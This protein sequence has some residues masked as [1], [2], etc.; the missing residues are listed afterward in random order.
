MDEPHISEGRATLTPE[1]PVA[2]GSQGVWTTTYI[3]GESGLSPG[4]ALRVTIPTGFSG[5]PDG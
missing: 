4:D 3:V 5:P 2:V 1:D